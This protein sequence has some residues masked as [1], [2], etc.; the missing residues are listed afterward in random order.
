MGRFGG[1]KDKGDFIDDEHYPD[2]ETLK[3]FKT[4]NAGEGTERFLEDIRDEWEFADV[5]Y[6]RKTKGT[7][8]NKKIYLQ[9][10]TGGWSGNEDII[11]ALQQN[12]TFWHWWKMTKVGGHYY[13][14][15]EPIK[16]EV[17]P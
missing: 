1:D 9:L 10:H 16:T 17:N 7:G 12:I 6:F 13:F 15:I 3:M 8:K 11:S 5:G 2:P 4:R 14:E